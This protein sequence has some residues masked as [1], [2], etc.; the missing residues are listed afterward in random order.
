ML[1]KASKSVMQAVVVEAVDTVVTHAEAIVVAIEAHHHAMATVVGTEEA[2]QAHVIVRQEKAAD[3]KV[4]VTVQ[5]E[6]E[7][8]EILVLHA[9][10]AVIEA[11]TVILLP[12]RV[13]AQEVIEE[14]RVE[15][16]AHHEVMLQE[17]PEVML[18]VLQEPPLETL[19]KKTNA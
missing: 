7:I 6:A 15:R 11:R 16:H 1:S 4:T 9:L 13:Q 10:Q 3:T 17:H 12:K 14:A 19:T 5:E 2:L 18:H 8:Q